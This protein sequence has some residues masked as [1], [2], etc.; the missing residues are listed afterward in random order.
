MNAKE[1]AEACDAIGDALSVLIWGVPLSHIAAI[2]ANQIF[3][4][5]T[6]SLDAL[7]PLLNQARSDAWDEGW[8][9]YLISQTH[10][11]TKT[12]PYRADTG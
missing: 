6:T 3:K 10:G 9:A 1:R 12:N 5:A 8:D 11:P 7:L 2:D 4:Y